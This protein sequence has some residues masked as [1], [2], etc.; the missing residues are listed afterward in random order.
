LS[1]PPD[2][3]VSLPA[4]C[5]RA[6]NPFRGL[7]LLE[8]PCYLRNFTILGSVEAVSDGS[9]LP[10]G[11]PRQ[12]ALLAR[13]LVDA[14]RVVSADCLTADLWEA[15]PQDAHGA[16]QNQVSRL[17]KVLGD[18]LVTKAPGYLV[19]VEPGELDLDRFRSLVA[20]A[21]STTGLAAR[22][23]LLREADGLFRGAPLGDVEAPFATSEAAAL[24]ELRLAAVEG[25]VDADLERGRH[26]ELVPEL[27]ALVRA[28]PLRE[29]LRGQQILAL[30]RCSRQA[31]ALDAYRAT[32]RMLDE[33]LGLEP[34]P[35]L[36][37]LERAILTQDESLA[38]AATAAAEPALAPVALVE[39]ARR[40]PRWGRIA[41]IAACVVLLLA[42]AA[43]AAVF[44]TFTA[45]SVTTSHAAVSQ[46][47]V[48]VV[49][50]HPAPKAHN[51]RKVHK[52]AAPVKH[53]A[54]AKPHRVVT[55]AAA[56]TTHQQTTRLVTTTSSHPARTL[57]PKSKP[58]VTTTTTTPAQSTLTDDF[59]ES[60]PNTKLW[61]VVGDGSGYTW[62]L[63]NG[64]L[65][66]TIPPDAQTGG[67]YNMVG[68]GWATQCRF[69]G[70]FDERID[71]QLLD[72]PSG[73]GAHVQINAWVF[74]T[75]NSSA[76][77]MT[78]QYS[79]SYNGNVNQGGDLVDTQDMQGTLRLVRT[80]ASETAYYLSKGTWVAIHTGTAPGQAQLGNPGLRDGE[81][82]DPQADP[83]RLRQLQRHGAV[84][85][86][87]VGGFGG[88]VAVSR[89]RAGRRAAASSVAPLAPASEAPC[90][91]ASRRP[92]HPRNE[93]HSAKPSWKAR[94]GQAAAT[95]PLSAPEACAQPRTPAS[96][97]KVK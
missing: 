94:R 64:K 19:R 42:L 85:R 43:A 30:Y 84:H 74:P 78:N 66:F 25:R 83:R 96:P 32:K 68:P 6:T 56:P 48:A 38:A 18:R 75:S 31:D 63:Q 45:S 3:P 9:V 49:A 95:S 33:E 8:I 88:T 65:V 24:D 29:R 7:L 79:E 90:V 26:A 44:A 61:N 41:L 27:G 97:E 58:P 86:L 67:T 28:H 35:A 47:A 59:S 73:S 81:R 57:K 80:G 15:P 39:A 54:A 14:N 89:G 2:C 71:Y 22:S 17:R 10:L 87:P 52:T 50:A 92:S 36:R 69:D 23:R 5:R 93:H 37:E 11:G 55:P 34:S 16:L 1:C 60:T 40:G 4:R 62:A 46:P 77:R 20:E 53:A 76:G 82:L 13:L 91:L 70:N 51:V 12:R 21:G 72:W